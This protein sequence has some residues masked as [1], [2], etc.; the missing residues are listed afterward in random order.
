VAV[1]GDSL[2]FGRQIFE[3]WRSKKM[4]TFANP[5]CVCAEEGRG[6]VQ[7]GRPTIAVQW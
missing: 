5:A 1:F 4:H 3:V 7:S 6:P 2:G